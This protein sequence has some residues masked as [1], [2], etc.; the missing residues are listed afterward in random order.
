[1]ISNN[2]TRL[3]DS[4]KIHYTV[5]ELPVEK[6]GA[7]ETASYLNLSPEIIFKTIVVVRP[8]RQT[9]VVCYFRIKCSRSQSCGR[10]YQR[11]KGE[12]SYS[13]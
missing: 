2:V 11:K 1:M 6:L 12:H 5:F 7:E 10:A 13:K 8:K 4:K 3:L 9:F